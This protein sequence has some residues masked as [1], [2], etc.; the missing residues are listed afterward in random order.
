MARLECA[1]PRCDTARCALR[2][3]WTRGE[4]CAT[5]RRYSRSRSSLLAFFVSPDL[6]ALTLLPRLPW[7]IGVRAAPVRYRAV[8]A[9]VGQHMR[10]NLRYFTRKVSVAFESFGI[11]RVT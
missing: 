2:S 7:R 9:S 5:S 10:R 4:I 8:R 3:A 6:S 1:L 11:L